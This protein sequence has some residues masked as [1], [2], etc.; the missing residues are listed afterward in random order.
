MK[1]SEKSWGM[2]PYRPTWTTVPDIY[3]YVIYIKIEKKIDNNF[4]FLWS[5]GGCPVHCAGLLFSTIPILIVK[6]II[7]C[8]SSKWRP[9][10]PCNLI[11]VSQNFC[12]SVK[13]L[14]SINTFEWPTLAITPVSRR[15]GVLMCTFQTIGV[16][17]RVMSSMPGELPS[18]ADLRVTLNIYVL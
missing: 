10:L 7:C 5:R 11:S 18:F 9:L 2:H 12:S 8:T 3:I 6:I 16:L 4:I 15:G 17:R 13:Y 1:Y 14:S